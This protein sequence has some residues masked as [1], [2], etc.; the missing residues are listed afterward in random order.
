MS[1]TYKSTW[2]VKPLIINFN[3]KM[4]RQDFGA[5]VRSKLF[6]DG[7]TRVSRA[8]IK[9]KKNNYVTKGIKTFEVYNSYGGNVTVD[10]Q[11]NNQ[12]VYTTHEDLAKEYFKERG[13]K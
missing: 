13:V 5:Y 12:I 1:K 11:N 8:R 10:F 2:N 7:T 4:W 3:Y 9:N 6:W